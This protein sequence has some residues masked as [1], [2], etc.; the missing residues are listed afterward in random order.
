M[1]CSPQG[2]SVHGILQARILERVA[3]PSSRGSSRPR[4]G[5]WVSCIAGKFFTAGS[6]ERKALNCFSE[7]FSIEFSTVKQNSSS[8]VHSM[9][10]SFNEECLWGVTIGR[11]YMKV[12]PLL[13]CQST[14]KPS[15]VC[16]GRKKALFPTF[17]LAKTLF[18]IKRQVLDRDGKKGAKSLV[19]QP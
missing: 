3:M 4:D 1:D 6:L 11:Y 5:T 10:L 16:L 17:F 9:T 7:S 19:A 13:E 12:D 18:T 2:S 14:E 15:G 8:A